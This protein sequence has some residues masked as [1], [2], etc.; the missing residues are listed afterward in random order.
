MEAL[1]PTV[2]EI[3]DGIYRI[4]TWIP[5]VTPIGFTFNQFL[6][7]ADEPLLFHTGHARHV[8]AGRRSGGHGAA[9]RVPALDH[10][11]ARRGR[12]VRGD[13]HVARRRAGQPGRV[14]RA[15]LRHLARTTCATARRG[16]WPRAR[17]STSAASGCGRS[18][19]RTCRTAG[20][21]RCCSRRRPGR[22]CAATCSPTS[23]PCRPSRPA[24][25]SS[26]R[27]RPSRCSTARRSPRTPARRCGR[28]ATC[29]PTTLA[30][31]HGSSFA[32]DGAPGAARPRRRLRRAHGR[33]TERG[34]VAAAAGGA[35]PRRSPALLRASRIGRARTLVTTVAHCNQS[36]DVVV[37]GRA[38]SPS[39]G[40][41]RHA[42]PSQTSG[43]G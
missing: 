12:R 3:A 41:D 38:R 17:C 42:R 9:R 18:R 19:R 36:L 16:R 15:R 26:R 22:C 39:F 29:A 4:S 21:P 8:P 14:R 11:R 20:R 23:A 25:S 28:S 31:M 35:S 33:L 32:G 6:V 1:H 2:D 37:A 30:I 5:D 24:T 34:A 27:W 10:L 7:A 40:S 43:P 13:E